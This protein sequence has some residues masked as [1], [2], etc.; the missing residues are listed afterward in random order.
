[1]CGFQFK[2]PP[3]LIGVPHIA[4][5]KNASLPKAGDG[6]FFSL[7]YRFLALVWPAYPIR[8]GYKIVKNDDTLFTSNRSHCTLLFFVTCTL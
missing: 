1:M 6:R 5:R 4:G 8:V 7:I 3:F 2:P